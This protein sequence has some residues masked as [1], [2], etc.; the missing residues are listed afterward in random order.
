M[1]VARGLDV[2][3]QNLA[4]KT[5]G[6]P[7]YF[8]ETGPV[9]ITFQTVLSGPILDVAFLDL[10]TAGLA[11]HASPRWIGENSLKNEPQE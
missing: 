11:G 4:T 8:D 2:A 1:H 5:I 3:L 10:P 7:A 9:I 6:F